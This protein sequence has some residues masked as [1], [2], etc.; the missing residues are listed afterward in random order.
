[1][2]STSSSSAALGV[3]ISGRGSNL[4]AIAGA[5]AAGEIPATI[6]IVISNDSAASGLAF[7]RER[8]IP[9]AV[10]H[11]RDFR[12][13]HDFDLALVAELRRHHVTLVCL[14][15]FMR[16]LGQDFCAAF[17]DAILNIH[18]SL[19]PAFPGTWAQRQALEHGAR[20]SGAT[21]HF[22]TPA[23]DAGPIVAQAAV[24][25]EDD[26]SEES[27]SAKILEVE[28]R[29]Y[30]SAI[31]DIVRGGWRIEGRRVIFRGRHASD[32]VRTE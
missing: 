10:I 1:M 13:R 14:A 6:A 15:G 32:I 8:G 21:V 22:V 29:L 28:H 3:L 11:H 4:R 27:L 20:V 17:P 24:S 9:T 31:R 7:A 16:L 26:D 25:V 30:P 19:L 18:P 23:L 5:I 2:T 12:S